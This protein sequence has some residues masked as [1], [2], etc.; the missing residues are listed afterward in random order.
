MKYSCERCARCLEVLPLTEEHV[1]P[2]GVGGVYTED[3]LCKLCNGF[4][5][6]E[7]DRP[8]LDLISTK[9]FRQ[10]HQIAGRRKNIPNVFDRVFEVDTPE[11]LERI[12]IDE[13]GAPYVLPDV[14]NFE[15]IDEDSFRLSV[16]VDRRDREMLPEIF[17]KTYERFFTTGEGKAWGWDAEQI[18][19]LIQQQIEHAKGVEF[20][21]RNVGELRVSETVSKQTLLLEAAK[22]AYEIAAVVA[23]DLFLDSQGA[24]E[25]RTILG[26]ADKGEISFVDDINV[27]GRFL[28]AV[29]LSPISMMR[30]G[31]NGVRMMAN[32]DSVRRNDDAVMFAIID[33]ADI[34]VEIPGISCVFL[35]IMPLPASM[36]AVRNDIKKRKVDKLI[37]HNN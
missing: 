21:T 13:D 22:I 29:E 32:A 17:R 25:F 1:F 4:F 33:G 7:I 10:I 31:G 3:M 8:Y 24:L 34:T 23:G 12:K 5:G 6:R 30:L 18:E 26:M 15:Q 36:Y 2:D 16:K 9:A 28:H 35:S 14:R 19:Q 27:L 11:G 20:Q 37:Q